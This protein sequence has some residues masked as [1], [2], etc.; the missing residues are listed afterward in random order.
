LQASRPFS[1]EADGSFSYQSGNNSRDRK[2][3]PAVK[4]GECCL[5]NSVDRRNLYGFLWNITQLLKNKIFSDNLFSCLSHFPGIQLNDF[6]QCSELRTVG[7]L[8]QKAL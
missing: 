7:F 1:V 6:L 8:F 3:D 4:A 2:S 5:E